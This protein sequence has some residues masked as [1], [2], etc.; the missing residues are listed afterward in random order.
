MLGVGFDGIVV[1]EFLVFVCCC[2]EV[3]IDFMVLDFGVE[4]VV[5]F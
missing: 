1:L 4:L 2:E 3:V 5:V